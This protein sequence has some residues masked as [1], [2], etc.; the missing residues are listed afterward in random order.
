M[1][2]GVEFPDEDLTVDDAAARDCKAAALV[3]TILQSRERNAVAECLPPVG[4]YPGHPI[5]HQGH[6]FHRFLR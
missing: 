2:T 1:K 5:V 6:L 3:F 4:R